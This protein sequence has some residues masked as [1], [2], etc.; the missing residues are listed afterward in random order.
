MPETLMR[1][2]PSPAP[3]PMPH[4][5]VGRVL[6]IVP[7][8]DERETI[9]PLVTGIRRAV[10]DA[11]VLVVDD[12]SPDGTAE[13]AGALGV[14]LG[15]IAVLYRDGKHGLG[16]AY[17]AGFGYGLT[18]GYDVL[19][20]MDADLSHDPAALPELLDA[21]ADGADLVIGARYVPGASIPDWTRG[22]RALSRF[23]NRYAAF[24]LGHLV[25]DLT[26]GYRAY[27]ADTLRTIEATTTTAA[28]YAFQIELAHRVAVAGLTIKEIPIT[29]TDRVH[30]RSKMSWRIA[31]EALA[32]VTWWR[33]RDGRSR[34]AAVPRVPFAM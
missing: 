10:P 3:Q 20:E 13:I 17:R 15:R 6:V 1:T 23:G 22:R 25:S 29:F 11:D 28:G 32:L 16:A 12:G 33:L 21:I 24:M 30:G 5:R 27:R 26:S 2:F 31:A 19:V 14:R 34:A 8:Y 9:V 4:S 7:T 18:H